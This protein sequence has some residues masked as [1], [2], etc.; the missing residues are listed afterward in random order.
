M[1]GEETVNANVDSSIVASGLSF[2]SMLN[3]IRF[4]AKF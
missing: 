4:S 2:Y 1:S 3:G